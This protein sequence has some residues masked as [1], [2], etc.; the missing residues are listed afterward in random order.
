MPSP[1]LRYVTTREQLSAALVLG[2]A[3]VMVAAIGLL[4]GFA[5][6]LGAAGAVLV[7][8]GILIGLGS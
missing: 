6:A 5:A 8:V 7:V 3:C 4:A 2:G 1:T